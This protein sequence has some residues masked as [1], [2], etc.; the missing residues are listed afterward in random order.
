MP[1]PHRSTIAR[2]T[3]LAEGLHQVPESL[4]W[5]LCKQQQQQQQPPP[6]G[7]AAG[8][9][10]GAS[11]L[12]QLKQRFDQQELT[13]ELAVNELCV[14]SVQQ[15]AL[16]PLRISLGMA[17]R[18]GG[19]SNW[20]QYRLGGLCV[21]APADAAAASAAPGGAAPLRMSSHMQGAL[22]ARGASVLWQAKHKPWQAPAGAPWGRVQRAAVAA[23]A[24]A[25]G[26]ESAVTGEAQESSEEGRASNGISSNGAAAG[27]NGTATG[28]NGTSSSQANQR[29]Q[30][31]GGNGTSSPARTPEPVSARSSGRSGNGA[32]ASAATSGAGEL[33]LI[34]PAQ[35]SEGLQSSTFWLERLRTD[36]QVCASG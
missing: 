6:S 31:S 30:R 29:A 25:A 16:T 4:P 10:R 26:S 27:S 36:L 35:I 14:E 34:T 32:A 2:A 24:A 9:G 8:S 15:Y 19:H 5:R 18:A 11:A 28:S 22:A 13:A 23:A 21:L 1:C 17:P 20:L 3:L 12:L 7:A 33:P